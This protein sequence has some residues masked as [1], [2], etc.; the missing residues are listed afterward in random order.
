MYFQTLDD[1]RE[2]VGVYVGGRLHFD[3]I[4][5][6]LERTWKYTGSIQGD[7]IEYAWIRCGGLSLEEACPPELKSRLKASVK[8]MNAFYKSFK[9]AKI[10]FSQHCLYDL[11]PHDA[12]IEFCD[13]KNKI[14]EYVFN[15]T[16]AVANYEFLTRVE[17]VLYNIRMR[18]LNIQHSDCKSLFTNTNSRLGLQK[19]L[20]GP[21]QIHYNIF[22][23]VTGRLTTFPGSFPILT[24][25]KDFRKII[26]P[27]NDWFVSFD[28]NG[29]EA[30]TVVALLGNTQPQGDIHQWNVDHIFSN[31]PQYQ[32]LT[33]DEAK[34]TFFG[35]LYN[36]DSEV[37]QGDF[38]DRDRLIAENYK[39][40]KIHT[41][42]NRHIPVV[43]R[44]AFNYL[45]QSTTSDLVLEQACA[46]EEFLKNT[47][48][49][50]SHV[51]H[52]EVVVDLKEE[53]KKLVPQLK[54]IFAKN[55]LDTFMVNIQAGQNYLDLKEL[56]I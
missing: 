8:K 31:S 3:H 14:T 21:S 1:K 38:Y 41:I 23:T 32:S 30:R 44:K 9:I 26:K 54:S 19:I 29:A 15:E 2:C 48:S 24:M 53:D 7:L 27:H 36:P 37:I 56:K 51:V 52:D 13:L 25:K 49:F 4:P 12:L 50:V 28:Y 11:I 33:R 18:G 40:G 42:F 34:T 20:D 35:W 6:N 39:D 55:R 45:I 17:K 5:D 16:E 46:I 22:G 10:D 43:P 47:D